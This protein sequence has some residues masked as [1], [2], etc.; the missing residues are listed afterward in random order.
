M[1]NLFFL[2]TVQL[3][4]IPAYAQKSVGYKPGYFIRG[5]D[6]LPFRYLEPANMK[7]GRKYPVILVL[8]GS[9]ERGSDNKLQLV[10][11]A[12]LFIDS[13]LRVNYPAYIIFPQCKLSKSWAR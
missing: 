2:L 1:R 3:F 7:E 12:T 11:G 13:S 4:I 10:H 6:T 9:G 5:N 8:H